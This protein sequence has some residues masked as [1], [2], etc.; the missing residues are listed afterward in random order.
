[1]GIAGGILLVEGPPLLAYAAFAGVVAA[2][3]VTRPTMSA[4]TPTL[5]QRP[6]E[7]TAINAVSSWVDSI[8][9]LVAPA[10]AGVLLAVSSP[11]WS[12]SPWAWSS[13]WARHWSVA[14]RDPC[15]RDRTKSV[16]LLTGTSQSD[17]CHTSGPLRARPRRTPCRRLLRSRRPRGSL[18]TDRGRRAWARLILGRIPER[19]LRGGSRTRDRR[20]RT[21]RGSD[22]ADAKR[23]LRTWSV[24]GCIHR[25]CRVPNPAAR[26]CR[27]DVRRP[28]PRHPRSWNRGRFF[29]VSLNRTCSRASSGSSR[30]SRW[31]ALA[32]GSLRRR[33][34]CCNRGRVA[35]PDR[36][37]L[38][39][40]ARGAPLGADRCSKW[41]VEQMPRV[42]EIG[43]LRFDASVLAV[44][45]GEARGVGSRARAERNPCG[46]HGHPRRRGR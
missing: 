28:R 14:C 11:G 8:S 4:L 45:G 46:R 38:C 27:V 26:R 5:A 17:E 36:D 10:L 13:P 23:P 35:R 9:I 3:T 1:M 40:P 43:L 44:V 18:S 22:A 25:S 39:A 42:V 16:K 34:A 7:L 6:E 30:R 2:M 21:A 20:Y 32:L 37:R 41:T 12:S 33:S 19:G 29:S 24:C 31:C 15:R